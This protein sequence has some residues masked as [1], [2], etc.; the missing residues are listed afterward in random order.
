MLGAGKANSLR[1]QYRPHPRKRLS[2]A[3]IDTPAPS[4]KASGKSETRDTVIIT[5]PESASDRLMADGL[6]GISGTRNT[7]A[8]PTHV[9]RPASEE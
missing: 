4:A 5:D 1:T 9:E 6:L 8:A 2:N 7:T 3:S